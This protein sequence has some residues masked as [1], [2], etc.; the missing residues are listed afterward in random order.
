MAA[1]ERGGAV[2]GEAGPVDDDGGAES[3]E[4]GGG[5]GDV[6][7]LSVVGEECVVLVAEAVEFVGDA[8]V[9][10][11][12]RA[13]P[14]ADGPVGERAGGAEEGLSAVGAEGGGESIPGAQE[15]DVDVVHAEW[16][17]GGVGGSSVGRVMYVELAR[18]GGR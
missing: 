4:R 16:F 7:R 3:A 9:G 1:E 8:G 5:E 17:A 18:G 11:A 10:G 15:G 12:E 2:G 14:G 6:V 13:A